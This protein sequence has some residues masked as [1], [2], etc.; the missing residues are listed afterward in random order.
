MRCKRTKLKLYK[1]LI[2]PVVTYG[3]ET[4]T[5][6]IEDENN[7]CIF[8]RKIVHRIYGP[9][10]INGEWRIK[11]NKEIDQLLECENIVS[12][13]KSNMTKMAGSCSKNA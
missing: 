5:M 4:W 10:Y 3:V 8:E 12:F 1:T 11:S 9:L 7:L 6:K 13:I 2:R